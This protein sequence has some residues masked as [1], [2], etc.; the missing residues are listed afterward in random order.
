MSQRKLTVLICPN[1][2]KGSLTAIEA[3]AS[4]EEGLRRVHS[5]I[6]L[7]SLPLADGG[8]GTLSTLVK[9]TGGSLNHSVVSGPLGDLV[10]AKWG[11]LGGDKSDTA[12]IEMSEASGMRLLAPE[13]RDPLNSS[14]YGTGELMLAAVQA[15]CSKLLVAIGGSATNDGG[16]G[17]AQALGAKLL[18]M[19]GKPLD[20]GG[21]ALRNLAVIDLSE[22]KL[23]RDVGVEVACDVDNP[24]TG[25][26]GA[27]Y[28]Y[29]PQKGATPEMAAQLE[30]SL[31]HY[32]DVLAEKLN[33][34]VREIPGSGAAGGLGAGL[35]AFCNGKLRSGVEL[36]LEA[37]EFEKYCRTSQLVITGEGGLDSQTIRG[38]AIAGVSRLAAKHHVPVIAL[39]GSLEEESERKLHD[40]GL[41]AAFTIIPGPS[42]LA[43]AMENAYRLLA[44]A[45]ER[46]ARLFLCGK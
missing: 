25:L 40:E 22:W 21:A 27:S 6:Q 3:A 17:M 30:E 33:V 23:P 12:V 5:S 7:I 14:T 18:D 8:D 13:I 36:T 45:A 2:Y 9:A 38:K 46:H 15:G 41:L 4:I 39:V 29:G 26:D 16:A 10:N 19:E 1:A 11:R 34:E 28:V 44:N 35:I 37:V 31:S 42:S 20:P 24:L 32:A 43:Y